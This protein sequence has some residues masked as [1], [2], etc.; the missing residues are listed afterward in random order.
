[1]K[2]LTIGILFLFILAMAVPVH[3]VDK[4]KDTGKMAVNKTIVVGKTAV[5][6][7]IVIGKIG[8]REI[9]LAEL[10]S[11]LKDISAR[12]KNGISESDMKEF[13]SGFMH[14]T[15]VEED[16]MKNKK[17][18]K[19]KNT[20]SGEMTRG[21]ILVEELVK[22]MSDKIIV[23]DDELEK[24]ITQ[25]E[26]ERFKGAQQKMIVRK[27]E[28]EKKLKGQFDKIKTDY[29][30][31]HELETV[32]V[33]FAILKK[34]LDTLT[35]EDKKTVFYKIKNDDLTLNLQDLIDFLEFYRF[36]GDLSTMPR[37]AHDELTFN[38][39]HR[40]LMVK[41]AIDRKIGETEDFKKKF[42]EAILT[43][44]M[45]EYYKTLESEIKED[46]IKEEDAKAFYEEQKKLG[47]FDREEEVKASHILIKTKEVALEIQ[48]RLKKGEKFEDLAA[49]VSMCPSGK[50]GGDLGY[51]S[52]GKMV[53]P[54]SDAAFDLEENEVSDLVKTQFGYHLIKLT[55]K[56]DA[57]P[58]PYA[59]LE[60]MIKQKLLREKRD[61]HIKERIQKNAKDLKMQIFWDKIPENWYKD[62]ISPAP[63]K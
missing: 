37:E 50:R 61:I 62:I 43:R 44:T 17:D 20:E 22:T 38:A 46:S 6:E 60:K 18:E 41:T 27:M 54:F 5:D 9:K 33:S 39:L 23:T 10:R 48:K 35:A 7:T 36:P 34:K 40:K 58:V 4:S 31:T 45:E 47:M 55:G 24:A 29:F 26:Y 12:L 42:N 51:F 2:K 57:E 11:S 25:K 1:M 3:A 28:I 32:E 30:K 14:K 15:F 52:R 19:F 53:K 16:V 8:K 56:K 63:V 21:T 49:E 59:Q 13:I